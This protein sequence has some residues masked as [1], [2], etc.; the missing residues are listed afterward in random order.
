MEKQQ[1]GFQAKE[2]L[3]FF[4]LPSGDLGDART[5]LGPKG[6]VGLVENRLGMA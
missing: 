2:E 4:S 6:L 1:P 3:P 5:I